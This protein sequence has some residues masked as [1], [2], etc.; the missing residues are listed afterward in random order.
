MG[1]NPLN[2][3]VILAVGRAELWD[4]IRNF[5]KKQGRKSEMRNDTVENCIHGSWM[6]FRA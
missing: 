5:C 4:I 6:G 2:R 1:M 3:T